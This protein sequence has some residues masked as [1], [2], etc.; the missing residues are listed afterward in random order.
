MQ[1][2]KIKV[3]FDVYNIISYKLISCNT[4]SLRLNDLS[5]INYYS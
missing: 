1:S 5:F 3:T 4:I 2:L